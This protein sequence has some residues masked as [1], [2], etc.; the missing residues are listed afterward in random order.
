MISAALD[1]VLYYTFPFSFLIL[2]GVI[3]RVKSQICKSELFFMAAH[4]F[5]VILFTFISIMVKRFP[6]ITIGETIW[7]LS[8]FLSLYSI[9]LLIGK[10]DLNTIKLISILSVISLLTSKYFFNE[11]SVF[12]TVS[13][14][15][16]NNVWIIVHVFFI[17]VG[18]GHVLIASVLSHI[19]ILTSLIKGDNLNHS[20]NEY[21]F[22]SNLLNRGTGLI[23]GGTILGSLWARSAWGRFWA[24]DPKEIAVLVVIVS[25]LLGI[26]IR[27]VFKK[28]YLITAYSSIISF[29]CIVYTWI[30]IN[31]FNDSLH[32]YGFSES[33]LFALLFISFLELLFFLYH[34]WAG[35]L[36]SRIEK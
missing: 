21:S 32:S 36:T 35:L 33:S 17:I 29:I 2:I 18:Y 9:Y 27:N 5:N 16:N 24:W 1:P 12:F 25:L 30:G 7:D 22:I 28:N 13:E 14:E 10:K 31:L 15:L 11:N 34:L 6:G 23:I 4:C 8:I 19:K 26:I 20:H 3:C